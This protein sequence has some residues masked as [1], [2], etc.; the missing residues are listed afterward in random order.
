MSN[1]KKTLNEEPLSKVSGGTITWKEIE[2]EM[3]S[4]PAIAWIIS[5]R[6]GIIDLMRTINPSINGNT[7]IDELISKTLTYDNIEKMKEYIKAEYGIN[8]DDL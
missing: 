5:K 2:K 7:F 4:M 8:V 3:P 1:K 6:D